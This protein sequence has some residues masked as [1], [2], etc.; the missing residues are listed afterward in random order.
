MSWI[1]FLYR[2]CLCWYVGYQ[3]IQETY[4][5]LVTVEASIVEA[6]VCIAYA[7]SE[8]RSISY[9]LVSWFPFFHLAIPS[10]PVA[11]LS[12]HSRSGFSFRIK[13][14]CCNPFN[15]QAEFE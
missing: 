2:S 8:G 4:C 1:A 7:Q 9:Y 12:S 6:T 10:S 13:I 14:K 5:I 11:Q 15:N 3:V